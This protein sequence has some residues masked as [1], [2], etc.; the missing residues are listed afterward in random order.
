RPGQKVYDNN[1][2]ELTNI[3]V[4]ESGLIATYL[5]NEYFSRYDIYGKEVNVF[6]NVNATF[7]KRS[8]NVTN[9]ILV[10]AS[11]KT[12][13]N[14]GDGKVYDL[15]NPPHRSLSAENSSPRPRKYS[16]IPFI[17]QLSLYAEENLTWSIGERELILQAGVRYD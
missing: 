9:R 10:G 16:S 17:N 11:F 15:N 13:G 5:P 12:D 6:A 4:G 14:L 7:S 8:G 1:G 3:P 2:N